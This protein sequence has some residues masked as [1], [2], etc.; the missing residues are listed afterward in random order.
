MQKP[1]YA[2]LS[3]RVP[4]A[5]KASVNAKA[6]RI[7]VSASDIIRFALNDHVEVITSDD[8][9]DDIQPRRE[10]VAA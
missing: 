9:S 4:V 7:G 10:M 8:N 6:K 5:I 2:W 3:V 1:E